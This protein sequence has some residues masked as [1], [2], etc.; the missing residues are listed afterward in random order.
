M[1]QNFILKKFEYTI[2]I[3]LSLIYI[4]LL[5]GM[6]KIHYYEL[7]SITDVNIYDA[8]KQYNWKYW[9]EES[10]HYQTVF[11]EF[12]QFMDIHYL[13]S[14]GIIPIVVNISFIFLLV[15]LIS[16]IIHNFFHSKENHSTSIKL[17]LMFC[18]IILLFSVIQDSSIVW[19]FNQQLFAAYFFPLLSYYLLVEFS[20]TR[21]NKY[22]YALL[23]SG[24]MITITTPYYFSALIVLFLMGYIFKIGWLKNSLISTI[25][26]LSLFFYYDEISNS[27]AILS[28]FNWD[29]STEIPLYILNYLGSVFIYVSFEPCVATSSVL[30]GI[31]LI[32]TFI[33]FSYLAIANKVTEQLYW[34]ILAFL[35]FYILTAF[36]SL[37]EI[38]NTN[39]VIFKNRYMTPSLIG[40]SLVLI[41]YIHHFNTKPII[42]RRILT[43]S[44]TLIVVLY[45]Y[46]ILTY[47]QYQKNISELKLA[48][49]V[50]KLGID[51]QRFLKRTTRSVYTMMFCPPKESK[52]KMSIFT[53]FDIKANI[54]KNKVHLLKEK[55]PFDFTNEATKK[56][57]VVNKLVSTSRNQDLQGGLDNIIP[58]VKKKNIIQINGWV[59]DDKEKKVPKWLMVLDKN[60][61]II[62]YIITGVLRKDVEMHYGKD[63]L[64]SGFIG[65]IR[66]SKTPS[67]LFMVDELGKKIFRVKY[68]ME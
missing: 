52:Q 61:N 37:A 21:N 27:M 62:G 24:M 1:M 18:I 25:L 48:V 2:F 22:F 9:F 67:T 45:F 6:I 13:N 33:Y 20:I 58:I 59:Y 53:V 49:V 32:S 16:I 55:N 4:L 23:L 11:S 39:T 8:M 56:L 28:L 31:F 7:A 19:M 47:R 26:L 66:Y 38:H 15:G 64:N 41:L 46:Q 17:V 36:G 57:L 50:L 3:L 10:D 30:G 54:I 12:L 34:V 65:Y 68:P 14:R 43:L 29:I 44:L 40:W 42:K 51:D 63:A 5:F 60:G 35:F